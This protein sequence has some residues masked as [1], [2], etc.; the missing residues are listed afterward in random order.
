M[1]TGAKWPK[2]SAYQKR[3]F[4]ADL[5][6]EQRESLADLKP[7][8]VFVAESPH[9][10][11]V[12]PLDAAHRRP[13]CGSAGREWW[14]MV[15]AFVTGDNSRDT[16]LERLIDLCRRGKLVVMNAVQYPI[17]PKIMMHY[18]DEA[19]PIEN[20][21]FAKVAPASYKKLKNS[22]EVQ[23]AIHALRHRLVHP[24]VR[25]LPVVSLGLDAQWFVTAALESKS[26]EGRHLT[27]VPHPSAW[28]RQGGK[29]RERARGQLR[30]LLGEAA[31]SAQ[32][33]KVAYGR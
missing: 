14:S 22:D 3:F 13:L 27:T 32:R 24:S 15:G 25:D 21:G 20:L 10:N 23:A 17:D 16:H 26:G 12:E 1:A 30:V 18:G 31:F 6:P 5:S 8:F 7:K 9:V 19:N 4:V 2:R 11:E 28:W 33:D 29:L